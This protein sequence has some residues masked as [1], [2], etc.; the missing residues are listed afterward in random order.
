MGFNNKFDTKSIQ[1]QLK[2]LNLVHLY[3][4]GRQLLETVV[5][6]TTIGDVL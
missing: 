6:K 1:L 3:L 5:I 2:N 4:S